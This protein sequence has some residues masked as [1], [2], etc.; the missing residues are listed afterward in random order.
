MAYLCRT[1]KA[2]FQA[3]ADL[4]KTGFVGRYAPKC[5]S[6]HI[7]TQIP[8]AGRALLFGIL[9]PFLMYVVWMSMGL[10]TFPH[11][12]EFGDSPTGTL[13]F[14]VL[15]IG[16]SITLIVSSTL[17]WLSARKAEVPFNKLAKTSL[18]GAIAG[19]SGF[20]VCLG[21]AWFRYVEPAVNSELTINGGAFVSRLF[22]TRARVR[23]VHVMS[24]Q[25]AALV[26]LDN[27]VTVQTTQ[28]DK[29]PAENQ[30]MHTFGR[31]Y[32]NRGGGLTFVEQFRLDG[33]RTG[34]LQSGISR[35]VQAIDDHDAAAISQ[36]LGSG[37][38]LNAVGTTS[39]GGHRTPLE[40]AAWEGDTELARS[41]IDRGADVN[42]R[43][44]IQQTALH[45]ARQSADIVT[46]LVS[47]GADVNARD[48]SGATPLHE[49]RDEHDSGPQIVQ[50][51]IKS[52]AN[53]NAQ[54]DEGETP[55][56]SLLKSQVEC[57]T[58]F[59]LTYKLP[60][61]KSLLDGKPDLSIADKKG[62]TVETIVA[63]LQ[64][65][66]KHDEGKKAANEVAEVLR[67]YRNVGGSKSPP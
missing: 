30:F 26:D 31:A 53:I 28:L 59:G 13:I 66:C 38:N 18:I 4:P 19:L 41:L 20:A 23:S 27:N 7:L 61:L 52:G 16:S 6:G 57:S 2:E 21:L 44:Y 64:S 54:N 22:S 29:L 25:K 12:F 42:F 62:V 34:G 24:D 49:D 47:K 32:L 17:S 46:L 11:I 43:G 60:V 48:I 51:L 15:W 14:V 1:C 5:P 40:L 65:N 3:P 33:V 35:L 9:L 67:A 58:T 36:L 45:N 56:L 55:V 8:G 39:S 63:Q 50:A 10:G 37:I